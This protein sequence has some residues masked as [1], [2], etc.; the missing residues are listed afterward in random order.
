M[1]WLHRAT[2]SIHY[3]CLHYKKKLFLTP[4]IVFY[5]K[6]FPSYSVSYCI[7]TTLH[8]VLCG[9]SQRGLHC[10]VNAVRS[11]DYEIYYANIMIL[12]PQVYFYFK[13]FPSYT[14][15]I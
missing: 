9:Y 8:D 4:S 6:G 3:I 12:L 15:T 1:L 11:L 13:G 14:V 7:I 2:H 10:T 5:F